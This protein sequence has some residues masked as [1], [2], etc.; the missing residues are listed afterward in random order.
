MNTDYSRCRWWRWEA[1]CAWRR[2]TCQTTCCRHPLPRH[3]RPHNK[4]SSSR[5][6]VTCSQRIRM[7]ALC[8]ADHRC[9]LL[10]KAA[11]S[12]ST[13][14][15][16]RTVMRRDG[17]LTTSTVLSKRVE[18]NESAIRLRGFF[19]TFCTED[20][21]FIIYAPPITPSLRFRF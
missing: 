1:V 4:S 18:Q 15:K 17:R 6:V 9:H 3:R 12:S 8:Q 16:A 11:L 5:L 14:N 7:L 21:L 10:D 19:I 20:Y 13:N 2:V